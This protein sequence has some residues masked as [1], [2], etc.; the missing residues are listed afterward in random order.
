M[1]EA[2]K[3]DSSIYML[4][5]I[6]SFTCRDDV[7]Q[8]WLYFWIMD[9]AMKKSCCIVFLSFCMTFLYDIL[10]YVWLFSWNKLKCSIDCQCYLHSSHMWPTRIIIT[11][12]VTCR[13]VIWRDISLLEGSCWRS[14]EF[15][16]ATAGDK[17]GI[18]YLNNKYYNWT[19]SSFYLPHYIYLPDYSDENYIKKITFNLGL[20]NCL[21][22]YS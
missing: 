18:L 13:A 11:D 7:Q 8:M 6:T 15:M 10:T 19:H 2:D 5:S 9:F 20:H 1:G 4:Q 12:T 22:L 17:S 14:W 21:K 3:S 16:D